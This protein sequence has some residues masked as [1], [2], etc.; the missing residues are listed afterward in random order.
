MFLIDFAKNSLASMLG[1]TAMQMR[2][3]ANHEKD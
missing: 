2:I 1:Y 3:K